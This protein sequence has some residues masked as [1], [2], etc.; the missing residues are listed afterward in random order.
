M[1]FLN[2]LFRWGRPQLALLPNI[3]T[4]E[5]TLVQPGKYQAVRVQPGNY[6]AT[7]VQPDHFA[8]EIQ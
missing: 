8:T 5:A 7:Y 1:R 6:T 4:T 3:K 2:F